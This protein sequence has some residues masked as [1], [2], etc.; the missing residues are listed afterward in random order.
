MSEDITRIFRFAE[1]LIQSYLENLYA[2]TRGA[3]VGSGF[4]TEV[5]SV[6]STLVARQATLAIGLTESPQSWNPHI[7]PLFLR[8]MIECLITLRW[9]RLDP[10][11]RSKEYINFGLGAEK[12]QAHHYQKAMESEDDPGL[13]ERIEKIGELSVAWVDSQQFQQ[14]VE[15]NLGSWTG[16]S[17]RKIAQASN[18][19]DLYN[20]AYTPFSAV[21]HNQWNHVGKFN[22]VQCKNPMHKQHYVGC[23]I[24][25]DF[26]TDFVYRAMKYFQLTLDEFDDFFDFA[27][28]VVSPADAFEQ[29]LIELDGSEA[30]QGMSDAPVKGERE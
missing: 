22:A 12:L 24:E 5:N 19:E 17:I 11:T 28:T 18:S 3:Q 23:I 15:V 20:F 1:K 7:A 27:P 25:T 8:S 21:V 6:F 14:F 29:A 9:I 30:E 4:E 16:Q 26:I 2:R 13:R 10:I